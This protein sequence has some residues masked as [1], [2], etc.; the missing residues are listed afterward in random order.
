VELSEHR[1]SFVR[2]NDV[3][4]EVTACV[5]PWLASGEWWRA[6]LAWQREEW[7]VRLDSGGL[8]RLLHRPDGWQLEGEYD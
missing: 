8:Y 5:G 6:D 3:A 1:P 2:S 4:G 7:D